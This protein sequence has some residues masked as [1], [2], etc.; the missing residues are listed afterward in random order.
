MMRPSR[1]DTHAP[2]AVVPYTAPLSS[3]EAAIVLLVGAIVGVVLVAVMGG[4]AQV[5]RDVQLQSLLEHQRWA[6][7]LAPAA[8]GS[9]P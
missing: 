8:S 2:A 5:A 7:L 1:Q 3:V 4:P 6:A 9:V